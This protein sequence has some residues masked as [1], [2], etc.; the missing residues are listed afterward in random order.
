MK[1]RICTCFMLTVLLCLAVSNA[2]AVDEVKVLSWNVWS[3][4]GSSKIIDIVVASGAD[5]VGFQELSNPANVVSALETATGLDWHLHSQTGGDTQ[6]ISRYPIVGGNSWGAEFQLNSQTTAW[7]FNVHLAPY[8]YQPYDLRDGTLAKNEA[9]V[10]AAANS[11]RG[12]QVTNLLNAIA[13]SGAMTTG[14]PVFFTGDFNE[15]SHLD[16]TQAAADATARTYDLKVEYPASKRITDV[17]FAD[18]FRAVRPDEVNDRGYTWTPGYPPPNL[19]SNEVHD[20]I[21]IVYYTGDNVT[22]TESLNIG[23]DITNPNTDMAFVGYPSDHRAVLA[24]FEVVPEPA[25]LAIL[26]LGGLAMLRR[27]RRS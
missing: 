3:A 6:I 11:A 24:T 20:R 19:N 21:D 8:P 17:G 23:L 26:A 27:R 14:A 5:I 1:R 12:G 16:W 10:I 18:A 9:A 7:L 25:S 4:D 2:S 15:P 22:A 13:S